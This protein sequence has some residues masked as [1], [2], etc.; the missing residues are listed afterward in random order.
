MFTEPARDQCLYQALR[1]GKEPRPQDH[2]LHGV[3][4][5]AVLLATAICLSGSSSE[6]EDAGDPGLRTRA[7]VWRQQPPK[8]QSIRVPEVPGTPVQYPSGTHALGPGF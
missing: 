2:L 8:S 4:E 5:E 1:E 7:V 6:P 3:S